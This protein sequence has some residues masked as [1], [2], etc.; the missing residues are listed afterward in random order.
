VRLEF[1]HRLATGRL[2]GITPDLASADALLTEIGVPRPTPLQIEQTRTMM[3]ATSEPTTSAPDDA[4]AMR[5]ASAGPAGEGATA[6]P[7]AIAVAAMLGSPQFQ[8]R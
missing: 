7:A 8:K 5:G 6:D 1:A 3:A 2:T 4:M